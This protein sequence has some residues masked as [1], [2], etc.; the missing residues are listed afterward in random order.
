[1]KPKIMLL[2][3]LTILLLTACS[4]A[5]EIQASFDPADLKFDSEKAFAIEAEMVTRFPDRASGYPNN[6]LA[7]EWIQTRMSA[8]GWDC[9]I[10]QWEI[11]NYSKPTSLNNVICK[12]PGDSA[13]EILVIA[14]LDQAMTTVQGADNDAAG[15]AILLH[16]GEIFAKEKPLPYTLVFVATDA[17]EYGM[18]GSGRYM[19]SHPDPKNIIAGFSMDNVGRSYYDGVKMEQIGQYRNYGSL[20][21]ALA[22]KEAASHAGLWPVVI[23]GVLDEM[24]GQMAPVSFMDQGTIVAAGVP[25]LGIAGRE[26]PAYA[27]E[28]YRMWHDPSDTLETQSASTVGNIGLV[29]E[30]L[31]RQLQSMQ[32]F[33]QESGPYLYNE[34]SN[35]LLRGWPLW[36]IFISFTAL[37]FLGSFLTARAPIAEKM[38]SWKA[39]LPHFLSFWLPFVAFVIM[40][41]MFVE[42]GLLLKFHRYP[43]TTKDPYL[44]QPNW[45]I[46]TLALVGLAL[47]L[48]LGRRI[49]RRFAGSGQEPPFGVIKSFA[50]FVV[51]L[52]AVYILAL[53][54][55]SL[56]FIV[57]LLLWF[58]I[59]GRKGLGKIL[60]IVFF[61]LGGLMLYALIYING[62]LTLHYNFAFFWM[63]LNMIA[64]RM[65]SFPT[66]VVIAALF[67]AGLSTVVGAPQPSLQRQSIHTPA[68]KAS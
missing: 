26:P 41:Y 49:G 21:L 20:W 40:L 13:R 52:A 28:H 57:P 63:L 43:A 51:G 6:K 2:F 65:V 24:I 32:S 62:F 7:A 4:A 23:P 27:A 1:M 36:L 47:L 14:H 33:P 11:I 53:N 29:A 60:D 45:L 16:L 5:P 46:F 54:P 56:L 8:A 68:A 37:F 64:D 55:F 59:T 9:S 3:S 19:E 50:L 35:Q 10:D 34:L 42:T 17:E 39:V 12:L 44:T 22:L 15:I 38:K 18:I 61:L 66:M 25:A 58:L 48:F 30:A 67:A 31:I